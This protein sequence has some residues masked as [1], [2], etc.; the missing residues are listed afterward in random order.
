MKELHLPAIALMLAIALAGC[1]SGSGDAPRTAPRPSSP[2]VDLRVTDVTGAPI[3]SAVVTITD[4]SA[5][6]QATTDAGGIA[7]LAGAPSGDVTMSVTAPGFEPVT[8]ATRLPRGVYSLSL[9]A[10]GEWAVGRPIALGA[11]MVERAPDGS[12]LTF[13]VDL[14]VIGVDSSAIETLTSADFEI[15]GIDCGWGGPRDCASDAAGNATANG[16]IFTPDGGAH[17]FGLQ[18]PSPKHPYLVSVLTERSRSIRDSDRRTAGL[19]S[20]FATVGGNDL[21][22]LAAVES[23]GG[24]ATMTVF[25]PYTSDGRSFFNAIDNLTDSAADQP[26]I[27]PSLTESIHRAAAARDDALTAADPTVLVLARPWLSTA[28]I[29]AAAALA[30]QLGVH[31]SVVDDGNYGL[32]EIAMRTGGFV[33]QY[34]DSRQLG[35]IFGAMDSLLARTMP[36]YR[37]Q[38]R[39][40]GMPGTFVVGGNAKVHLRVRVPTPLPTRGSVIWFDVPIDP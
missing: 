16:G 6:F 19:K 38:F 27:L 13:S 33:A 30:R 11:R 23:I 28:E 2:D 31:I 14:A 8:R 5:L 3:A 12:T 32:P 10:V 18:P 34:L 35:P 1:D 22:S 36:Y 17:S 20:F 25:G 4:G 21:V 40:K 24:T 7:S 26:A 15:F 37:A 9:D 39:I 29:D